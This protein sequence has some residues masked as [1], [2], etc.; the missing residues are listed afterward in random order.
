MIESWMLADKGLLKHLINAKNMCDAELGLDRVPESYA[1]PKNAIENAIRVAM[2]EQ[3]KKKRNMVGIADLYEILGN[4][5]SLER[6]RTIPSFV[7][8]EESVVHVF[9]DMGLMR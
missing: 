8:F 7:K 5:L 9:K 3:P 1:D 6:L 2:S 4:R